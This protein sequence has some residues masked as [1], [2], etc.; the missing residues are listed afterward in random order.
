MSPDK[1]L[2][3]DADRDRSLLYELPS[4]DP[5]KATLYYGVLIGPPEIEFTARDSQILVIQHCFKRFRIV[6]LATLFLGSPSHHSSNFSM[7]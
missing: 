3:S 5:M 6:V 7:C 2:L 4:H 1:Y